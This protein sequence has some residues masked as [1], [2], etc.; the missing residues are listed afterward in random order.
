MARRGMLAQRCTLPEAP[1]SPSDARG[2]QRRGQQMHTGTG[3]GLLGASHTP[4]KSSLTAST[5]PVPGPRL[6]VL[7]TFTASAGGQARQHPLNTGP[8]PQ[9]QAW[10]LRPRTRGGLGPTPPPPLWG[11]GSCTTLRPW[12]WLRRSSP[13]CPA[14]CSTTAYAHCRTVLPAT[15]FARTGSATGSPTHGRPMPHVAAWRPRLRTPHFISTAWL[16]SS[17]VQHTD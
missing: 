14:L 6:C 3:R 5:L 16:R 10:Q 8:R 13:P 4:S 17:L 11:C 2:Q 15:P 7:A 9:Q 12:Q 1:P